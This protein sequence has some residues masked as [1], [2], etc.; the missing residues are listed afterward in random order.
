M[1]HPLP[2]R[3]LQSGFGFWSARVL[4]S[5]I[6]L[7]VFTELARGPR[8]RAQLQRRLRLDAHAAGDFLDA[9]VSLKLLEREGDDDAAVYV[10]SREAGHY[11][12]ARSADDLGR[13]MHEGHTALAAAWDQLSAMLRSDAAP[14]TVW[15]DAWLGPWAR[16]FGDTLGQRLSFAHTGTLLD[17]QGGAGELACALADAQPHLQLT[18][19][20]PAARIDAARAYIDE[21]GVSARVSAQPL[22]MAWPP[23]DTVVLNRWSPACELPLSDELALARAALPAGG[24][25]LLIDHLL[26]D[27]RR[28]DAAAL[29][30]IL[31]RRMAGETVTT[32]TARAAQAL[33]ANAGFAR[34]QCMPLLGGA[35]VVQAFVG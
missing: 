19:L 8:T 21:R 5:A 26:D 4:L 15:R 14:R 20:V 18:T 10:N 17:V 6:E 34:T 13:W 22:L 29:M 1:T 28:H 27:A 35:S 30:A 12:D 7:G 2:E 16:L 33:C 3:I 11:L 9:L 23:A 31:S 32:R 25:L 24:R